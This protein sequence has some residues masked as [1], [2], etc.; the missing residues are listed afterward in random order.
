[1]AKQKRKAQQ[2]V[3][4]LG[5][6]EMQAQ[7]RFEEVKIEHGYARRIKDLRPIDKY[8]RWYTEDE[9]KGVADESCRGINHD[10]FRTADRLAVLY[11]RTILLPAQGS[12][13][14]VRVDTSTMP[15]AFQIERCMQAVHDY[16]RIARHLN[17][18]SL[19]IA[20]AICCQGY[21]LSEVEQRKGWRKGYAI[22]RLREALDELAG[23][24]RREKHH[25]KHAEESC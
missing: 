20:E 25:A 17:T 1:M 6:P 7:H 16:Q 9:A 3:G 24:W 19:E 18:G 22:V 5:T 4:D 21:G 11:A 8:H 10:Q 2:V 14:Q 15:A 13:Q 23:V 12:L